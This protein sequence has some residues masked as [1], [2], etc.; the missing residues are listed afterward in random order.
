[1]FSDF[2]ERVMETPISYGVKQRLDKLY[3]LYKNDPEKMAFCLILMDIFSSI[4]SIE[5]TAKAGGQ[6]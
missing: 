5:Q 1:M 4:D 2:V 3:E 6:E